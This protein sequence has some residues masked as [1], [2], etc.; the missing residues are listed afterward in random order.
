[1]L[2]SSCPRH[3]RCTI[4][5]R[6]SIASQ[7]PPGRLLLLSVV[8]WVDSTL[9]LRDQIT[10]ATGVLNQSLENHLNDQICNYA[11]LQ[12]AMC[13]IVSM[14]FLP[15]RDLIKNHVSTCVSVFLANILFTA[16]IITLYRDWLICCI[17]ISRMYP[18]YFAGYVHCHIVNSGEYS[19]FK[20]R[21]HPAVWALPCLVMSSLL[22]LCLA[23]S[24]TFVIFCM[25]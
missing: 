24:G 9:Y 2:K 19:I 18:Y 8:G 10:N 22:F 16:N 14:S 23:L 20:T 12:L 15:C 4:S 3:H 21:G 13:F 1:M 7:G 5:G 17:F 6:R 25:T 11:S